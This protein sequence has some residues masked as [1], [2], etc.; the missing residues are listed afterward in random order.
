MTTTVAEIG[1]FFNAWT[2]YRKVLDHN[3]MHHREIYSALQALLRQRFAGRGFS[4]LDLGCGDAS[5]LAWALE[6]SKLTAYTGFDLSEPALALART[7]IA[8]LG[9]MPTLVKTDFMEGL[10][11]NRSGFDVV[12]ISYALHHLS[13]DEKARFFQLAHAALT[14][15]GMLIV[16]DVM[17]EKQESRDAYVD[18]YCALVT[19][20]WTKCASAEAQAICAHVRQNDLPETA[21]TLDALAETAGFTGS[22]TF[23][24]VPWHQG[25]WFVK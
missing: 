17:R 16:V 21:D 2:T 18:G 13:L 5:F 11:N 12:F 20:E 15:N 1:E 25:M 19:Q 10:A 9:C 14:G 23:Y 3:Y 8:R 4:V 24:Q 22:A 7:N 6:G